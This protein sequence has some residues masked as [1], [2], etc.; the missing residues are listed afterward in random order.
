[1]GE[2]VSQDNDYSNTIWSFCLAMPLFRDLLSYPHLENL[3]QPGSFQAKQTEWRASVR[4]LCAIS[5][6]RGSVSRRARKVLKLPCLV[7]H[8]GEVRH[9]RLHGSHT[10]HLQPLSYSL[11]INGET[12]LKGLNLPSEDQLATLK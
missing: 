10:P 1:M 6:E 12:A 11:P 2:C 5:R 3:G 9:E 8:R 7:S 4:T